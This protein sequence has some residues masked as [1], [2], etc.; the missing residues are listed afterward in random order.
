MY[1]A[2][3]EGCAQLSLWERTGLRAHRAWPC[4]RLPSAVLKRTQAW[5]RKFVSEAA[6]NAAKMLERVETMQT[7]V[8]EFFRAMSEHLAGDA[9]SCI[10]SLQLRLC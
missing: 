4:L 8:V 10:D 6:A 5:K 2:C 3:G 1:A 9:I 7:R